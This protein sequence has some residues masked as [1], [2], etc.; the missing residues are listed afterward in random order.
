MKSYQHL[1]I[2]AVA[3]VLIC[4]LALS[5]QSPA[6]KESA[7]HSNDATNAPI[8]GMA[9]EALEQDAELHRQHTEERIAALSRREADQERYARATAQSGESRR[10]I[11]RSYA[12]A[13]KS[14]IETN[15]SLYL[16]LRA[17]AAT[18]PHGETPCTIC[19]GQSYL[20]YCIM[21]R[22][23]PGKCP[24]CQGHGHT[25]GD[26]L[27]PTCLG[28]GKCFT[29]SGYNRMLCPYC[30]DGAVRADGR[31]PNFNLTE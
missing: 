27:C 24:T 6:P 4:T 13:W 8:T 23:H 26:E 2:A 3:L 30:D 19:D 18:S 31:T 28:G 7:A 12:G 29:C 25:A 21:C 15:R 22:A 16:K 5:R 17:R 20:A 1:I 11:N 14:V 10:F 9:R